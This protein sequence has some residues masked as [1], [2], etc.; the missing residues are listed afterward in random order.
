MIHQK[1]KLIN[2][3]IC[4]DE[5]MNVVKKMKESAPGESGL[6]LGFYKKYL[7]HFCDHFVE[8][9]NN[10][11]SL[12]QCFLT[13]R[14]KLKPKNNKINKT[15]N[16]LRPISLT[17][18]EYRIFTKV[19][20]NRIKLISHKLIGDYQT[21]GIKNRRINDNLTLLRDLI[22]ISNVK[23]Y[24]MYVV[25]VDQSKAFDRIS[26]KYLNKLLEHVNM[27]QFLNEQIKRLYNDSYSVFEINKINTNKIKINSGIK[28]GCALSMFL[29]ILCIEECLVSINNNKNINGLKICVTNK[30][31]CKHSANA[32]DVNGILTTYDSI[33]FFF[34]EFNEW[35]KISGAVI[36]KEKTQILALNSIYNTF[37]GI[38]FVN[39]I[40]ILGIEFNNSGPSISNIT[41]AF[42][43]MKIAINMWRTC[44]LS[45]IERIVV[46]RTFILSKIWHLANI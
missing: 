14:V 17:N 6:T 30:Y 4:V 9:L 20:V 8:I 43:K 41:N 34:D 1:K 23:K 28:Q 19:L 12:P 29:Y 46:V 26:H 11:K 18:F 16:D 44:G 7:I 10:K 37:E 35:G 22:D 38:G 42:E 24:E 21:C 5:V 36:N 40:K 2:S 3:D 31:E 39:K 13:S 33:K 15:I 45:M 25:S 27:G 32:D